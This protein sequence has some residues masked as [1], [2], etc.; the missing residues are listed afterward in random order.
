[1][2]Y[3]RKIHVG[4]VQSSIWPDELREELRQRNAMLL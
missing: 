1:M 4:E 2:F 3:L